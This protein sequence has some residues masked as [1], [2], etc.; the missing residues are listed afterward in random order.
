M[1]RSRDPRPYLDDIMD[2]IERLHRYT[3]GMTLTSFRENEMVQDAVIRRL[4]VIGEAVGYLPDDLKSR[5]SHVPW[6]DIKDMRNRLIHDYGHV[7]SDLV[8]AV[9]RKNIPALEVEIRRILNEL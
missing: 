6:R 2:C 1:K 3:E 8:W 7:D 4:E 9:V 5:Y